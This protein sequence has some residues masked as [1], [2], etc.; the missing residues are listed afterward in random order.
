MSFALGND[1]GGSGAWQR[2]DGGYQQYA[3]LG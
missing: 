2:I 1:A 3:L